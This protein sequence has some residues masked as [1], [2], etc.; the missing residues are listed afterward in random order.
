MSWITK[1]GIIMIAIGIGRLV[2]ALVLYLR[3]ERHG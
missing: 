2:V 3:E 1:L